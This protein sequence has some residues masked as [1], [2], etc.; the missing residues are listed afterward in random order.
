VS[1]AKN[2]CADR[3]FV[4]RYCFDQSRR[5]GRGRKIKEIVSVFQIAGHDMP[6]VRTKTWPDPCGNAVL[7]CR[8]GY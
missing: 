6:S 7:S 4:S 1:M 2:E 8:A 5:V 3:A